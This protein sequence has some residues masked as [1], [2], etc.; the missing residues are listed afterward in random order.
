METIKTKLHHYF[1]NIDKGSEREAY[2]ELRRQL[3]VSHVGKFFNVRSTRPLTVDFNNK[4]EEVELDPSFLFNNQWN[5]I[6]KGRRLFD[7]YEEIFDNRHT[8]AGHWLENTPEMEAIRQTLTCGYCGKYVNASEPHKWHCEKCLGSEYLKEKDLGLLRLFPVSNSIKN[9]IFNMT[10]EERAEILPAYKE[11]QGL[12][13]ISRE[14]AAASKN[15]KKVAAL[16]PKAEEKGRE[17][18]ES[19]KVQTEALTWL[20]DHE[21]NFI[22]NVIYYDHTKRFCF[23]WLRPLAHEE[24]SKLL[25]VIPEFPFEYEFTTEK[26]RR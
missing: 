9:K 15:R 14:K 4:T 24:R 16:I 12:G 7:W 18:L 5:E 2:E 1:F 19:A 17:L 23:G 6:G 20:L 10:E 25:A 13:K 26:A 22:D 11:A 21:L 3:E 8:K